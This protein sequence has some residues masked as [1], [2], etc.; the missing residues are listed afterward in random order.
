[1]ATEKTVI[2]CGSLSVS[3]SGSLRIP[4]RGQPIEVEV[5]FSDPP[6]PN[7]GCGPHIEDTIDIEVEPK[8]KPFPMWTIRIAWNVVSSNVREIAWKATVL[9]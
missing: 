8:L 4:C 7:P 1:M 6:P 3:G 2:Y 5:N 9:V